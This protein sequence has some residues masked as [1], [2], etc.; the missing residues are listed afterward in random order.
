M[1]GY[2]LSKQVSLL[3]L[4][5]NKKGTYNLVIEDLQGQELPEYR[6]GGKELPA[7]E[8]E[9]HVGKEY[10][11]ALIEGADK[12]FGKPWPKS[13]KSKSRILYDKDKRL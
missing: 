3:S 9:N 6:G 10:A 13:Q 1:K 8:I 2:N 4:T 7:A 5:K 12:N 11:K